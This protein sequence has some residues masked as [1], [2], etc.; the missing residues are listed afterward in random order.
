MKTK[1]VFLKHKENKEVFCLFV[2]KKEGFNFFTCYAHLGQHSTCNL[3]Y[4]KECTFATKREYID[5]ENELIK[6]VGYDLSVFNSEMECKDFPVWV[7]GK[8]LPFSKGRV[9]IRSKWDKKTEYEIFL[10]C[11]ELNLM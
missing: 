3:H 10:M 4:I 5:L 9:K 6:Q 8:L 2:D 11:E 7:N 1:A